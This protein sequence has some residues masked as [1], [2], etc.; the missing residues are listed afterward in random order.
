MIQQ[1]AA[2]IVPAIVLAAFRDPARQDRIR[3]DFFKLCGGI[4]APQF[5]IGGIGHDHCPRCGKYSDG[6]V[7][8]IQ[9]RLTQLQLLAEA[10]R[11]GDFSRNILEKESDTTVGMGLTVD[12]ESLAGG[13]QP[14]FKV[15]AI[16]CCAFQRGDP[17]APA[18]VIFWFWHALLVAQGIQ[19]FGKVR[20]RCKLDWLQ[21]GQIDQSRIEKGKLPVLVK[22][23]EARGQIGKGA[24]QGLNE[25][26]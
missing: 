3:A 13:Q 21:R 24:R 20:A 1:C 15:A 7:H 26:V 5:V 25:L 12:A 11:Q 23:R 8:G 4:V 22:D 9:N 2:N 10:A 19:K 16:F 17:V 18:F 14:I 6:F